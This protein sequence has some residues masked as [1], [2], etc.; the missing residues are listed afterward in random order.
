[1]SVCDPINPRLVARA[2]NL[3]PKSFPVGSVV[4]FLRNKRHSSEKEISFGT[5]IEHY[6]SEI[7]IQLYE[8]PDAREIEGVPIKEFDT[9]TKWRK[10]PKGWTWDMVLFEVNWNYDRF[11]NK[12]RYV[13]F[14]NPDGILQA[15]ND[16]ILVK[17][18]END[19]ASFRSEV[20]SKLGWR[21]IREYS[22]DWM[23][24][25][26]CEPFY[27]CYATWE[28][29]QAELDAILEENQRQASLTDYEWSVEQMDEK[30]NR[31]AYIYSIAPEAKKQVRDR[32]LALDNFEDVCL[33]ISGGGLEW[34]YDRNKRWI[35]IEV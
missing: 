10:L 16:G 14:E 4:Y 27:Q 22:E 11:K 26:T 28:E 2:Q 34:K 19:H 13:D 23:T 12:D 6:A 29:A 3:N 25:Y 8:F 32:L 7:A 5:V 17:V 18:S 24:D 21:I 33:R 35:R 20:D 30:L 1:M 15:I 31:W 9:P